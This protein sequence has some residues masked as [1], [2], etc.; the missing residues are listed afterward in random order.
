M[1]FLFFQ[2]EDMLDLWSTFNESQ[3]VYAY[4]GYDLKSVFTFLIYYTLFYKNKSLGFG[5]KLKN[6]LRTKA[7][8]LSNRR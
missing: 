8:L 7:D 6:K 5:K 3:P 4:K 2:S 1:F